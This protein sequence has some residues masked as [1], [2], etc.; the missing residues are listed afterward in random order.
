[1]IAVGWVRNVVGLADIACAWIS[2]AVRGVITQWFHINLAAFV[3]HDGIH[4]A[5]CCCRPNLLESIIASVDTVFATQ[6]TTKWGI[7]LVW[8]CRGAHNLWILSCGLPMMGVAR[9]AQSLG[10][11]PMIARKR[12][13][14][15]WKLSLELRPSLREVR[16]L[17]AMR[18]CD[19]VSLSNVHGTGIPF[20]VG[21]VVAQWLHLD[22]RTLVYRDSVVVTSSRL[23]PQFL[24]SVYARVGTVLALQFSLERG[25]RLIGRGKY[26]HDIPFRVDVVPTVRSTTRE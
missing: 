20:A 19:V 9:R 17:V 5:A 10:L 25:I 24:K 15:I 1:L 6:S 2:F 7:W 22:F 26:A 14:L 16:V 11:A 12:T 21:G 13:E 8:W 3:N 4:V 18:I 23:S